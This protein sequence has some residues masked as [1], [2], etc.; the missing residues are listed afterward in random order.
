MC[1]GAYKSPVTRGDMNFTT[2][3]IANSAI[4]LKIKDYS[5]N[6]ANPPYTLAL[7]KVN[8]C[9]ICCDLTCYSSWQH[10]SKWKNQVAR[11]GSESI[12][13]VLALLKADLAADRMVPSW[14]IEEFCLRHEI[15]GIEVSSKIGYNV[16]DLFTLV[17]QLCI[18]NL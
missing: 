12:V 1:K 5:Q 16:S 17:A 10:V 11:N 7:E 8:A 6:T 2:V 13:I 14:D 18:D 4:W 15:E 3:R 9:I